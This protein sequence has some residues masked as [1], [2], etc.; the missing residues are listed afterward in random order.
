MNFRAKIVASHYVL[1]VQV[2]SNDDLAVRFDSKKIENISKLSGIC[3]RRVCPKNIT[4]ADLGC[5]AAERMLDSL[6]IDKSNFDMLI[7]A[8]QTRDYILPAS[9]FV[10][11]DRLKMPSS[12]GAFDLPIGCAAFPYAMSIANG[13]V[14]S[15]QCKKILLIISDTITH[16]INPKDR[17]LVPLHGDGAA[18]FVLE[19]SE[20]EFGF[21]F[22]ET[23]SDSSGWKYLIVPAGGMR[24]PLSSE[25][26]IEK[27][28]IGGTTTTDENLQMNGEAVFHFSITAV[29]EAI[30]KVLAKHNAEISSYNLVLLHQANKLMLDSIYNELGVDGNRRFFFMEKIGN[31]SAAS[32]PVLLAEALRAGKLDSGGRL[33]LSAFGVGLTWGIF[34]MKFPPN[35]KISAEAS[36]EF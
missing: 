7:F 19:R 2:L 27:A 31:L 16:L 26:K 5:A 14:A 33:L 21:E 6:C 32:S 13:L 4:A 24:I 9:A 15:G 29:P 1:P 11:H 12:C 30:R 20:D 25:T 3:E 34:S 18:A 28:G 17:G 22:A 8:S 35:T 36:T 10:L 23:G